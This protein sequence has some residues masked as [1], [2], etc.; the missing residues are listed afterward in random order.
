MSLAVPYRG[1]WFFIRANDQETKA[2]FTVLRTL[3]S[4]SIA[5]AI[6]QADAPVLTLSVGR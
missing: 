4:I 1:Y 2:F 3:W 6:D 5:G